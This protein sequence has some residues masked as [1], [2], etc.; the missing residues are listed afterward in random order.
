MFKKLKIA[1]C[2]MMGVISAL[3]V[4]VISSYAES[5]AKVTLYGDANYDEQVDLSDAVL[6]MQSLANPNKYGLGVEKG[7]TATGVANADVYNNGDGIT[8]QDAL[9]IQRYLLNL[10]PKLPESYKQG[11]ATASTTTKPTT[12][13]TT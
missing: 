7:I 1:I 11:T 9:S 6:I 13:T 10:I 5:T 3:T 2:I 12:T 4:G 8:S